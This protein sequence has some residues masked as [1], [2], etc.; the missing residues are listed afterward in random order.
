VIIGLAV[1][2]TED[3]RKLALSLLSLSFSRPSKSGFVVG[4]SVGRSF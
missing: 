2:Y 1:F 3:G 4:R